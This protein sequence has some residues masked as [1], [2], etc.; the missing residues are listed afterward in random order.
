MSFKLR[1]SETL[2]KGICRI[3]TEQN[4][5]ILC[6]LKERRK[7]CQGEAIH[8]A[9]KSVKKMRALLRLICRDLG[10]AVFN[11]ENKTYRNIGREL[12][13]ARDAVVLARSLEKLQQQY[14]EQT[15]SSTFTAAKRQIAAGFDSAPHRLGTLGPKIHEKLVKAGKRIEAWPLKDLEWEDLYCGIKRTYKLGR[16]SLTAA[17]KKPNAETLHEWRKRVKDLWYHVRILRLIWPEVLGD[18]AREVKVLSEYLGEDHDLAMLGETLA[19]KRLDKEILHLL[20]SLIKSRRRQL[21]KAAFD[22]GS[23]IYVE[24]PS[25]FTRRMEGYWETWHG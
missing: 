7:A 24:K 11:K 5:S 4:E 20:Q 12:S 22:L 21:Q 13:A 19:T 15:H 18:L 14:R 23:R 17:C 9:R 16:Q 25:A 6:F 8:D 2:S 10:L 3:A 1:N